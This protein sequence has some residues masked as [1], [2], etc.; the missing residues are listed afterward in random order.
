MTKPA[1]KISQEN[2]ETISS[3]RE[4]EERETARD[5]CKE[6]DRR[7]SSLHR[8]NESRIRM[9]EAEVAE[10]RRKLREHLEDPEGRKVRDMTRVAACG[11]GGCNAR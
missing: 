9:L 8:S 2:R 7:F 1:R 6:I 3:M 11:N 4:E 5:I 10:L